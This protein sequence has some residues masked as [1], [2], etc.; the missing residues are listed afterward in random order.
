VKPT[1][2]LDNKGAFVF[3]SC[4]ISSGG[5]WFTVRQKDAKSGTHRIKANDLPIRHT[6]NEAQQDLDAY[7]KSHDWKEHIRATPAKGSQQTSTAI[8]ESAP[9]AVEKAAPAEN[10][11]SLPE[12]KPINL[13][14]ECLPRFREAFPFYKLDVGED[15]TGKC[16]ICNKKK[17][18]K[19]CVYRRKAA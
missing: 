12:V 19:G 16:G 14:P 3:V 10:A 4:G 9:K 18:V 8:A 1:E 15:C 13:C 6:R 7:A 5:S 2:Y 17:P 11:E